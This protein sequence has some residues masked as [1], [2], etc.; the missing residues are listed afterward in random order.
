MATRAFVSVLQVDDLRYD[1]KTYGTFLLDVPQRLGNN[2]A[3]DAAANTLTSAFPFLHTRN[4][5]PH[6]LT[7][8][9]K[10]LRT[11]RSCLD[12]PAQAQ[13]SNTLCA[14]YLIVICQVVLSLS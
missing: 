10:S 7:R 8:H 6:V 14:I 4:Y 11:L 1:L 2:R 3:L 5:P 12:D 9:N 13:T